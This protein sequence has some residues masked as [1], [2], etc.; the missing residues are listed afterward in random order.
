MTL[1]GVDNPPMTTPPKP[2]PK[3]G[4]ARTGSGP[5]PADGAKGMTR[6][7][8]TIDQEHDTIAKEIGEGDRSLG[9][10]RALKAFKEG[11]QSPVRKKVR[12][13]PELRTC[14]PK[15]D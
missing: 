9:I 13:T 11:T 3:R 15:E 8:I 12:K 10:R 6:I 1:N 14:E 5:K 2:A 7:N 4:G